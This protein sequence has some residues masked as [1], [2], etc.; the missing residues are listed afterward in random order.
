MERHGEVVKGRGWEKQE[1]GMD[2]S[3]ANTYQILNSCP[4]Y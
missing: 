3:S 4:F 2:E 1:S